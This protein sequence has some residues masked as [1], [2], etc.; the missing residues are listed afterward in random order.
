MIIFIFASAAT[1][2]LHC[3][4]INWVRD[5]AASTTTWTSLLTPASRGS[6][7]SFSSS[8]EKRLTAVSPLNYDPSPQRWTAFLLAFTRSLKSQQTAKYVWHRQ[9]T[10]KQW[11]PLLIVFSSGSDTFVSLC[12]VSPLDTEFSVKQ[13]SHKVCPGYWKWGRVTSHLTPTFSL[14]VHE[15]RCF[16]NKVNA[17]LLLIWFSITTLL[18]WRNLL[19]RGPGH[20][21]QRE[22]LLQLSDITLWHRGTDDVWPCLLVHSRLIILVQVTI[23]YNQWVSIK[24]ISPTFFMRLKIKQQSWLEGLAFWLPWL[25]FF[26]FVKSILFFFFL[27]LPSWSIPIFHLPKKTPV[28]MALFLSFLSCVFRLFTFWR[29][30]GVKDV[31]NLFIFRVLV[32]HLQR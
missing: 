17:P 8:T 31:I 19:P 3:H 22:A 23:I 7:V 2:L 16:S 10:L 20:H 28:W 30:H 13:H 32:S 14:V 26:L 1:L 11:T 5:A 29:C 6:Q 21:C 9:T 24:V 12:H 25:T 4:I 15:W 18:L 27:P